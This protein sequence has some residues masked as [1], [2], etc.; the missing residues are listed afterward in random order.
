MLETIRQFAEEQLAATGTIDEVRDRHARYFAEQAVAHWD[1][2]DG[3]RQRV[4]VDW[5]DVEFAN[6]RA[7]FRWAADQADLVTAAAIAAHTAMLACALQ[8]FEPVGWAE[9]ILDAATAADLPQLPRLYTAASALLRTPGAPTPPSAT[10]RP[11]SRWRPIP[12]TTRS[13][14]DGA[15]SWEAVAHLLRRSDRPLPGDLRRPRPPSPGSLTSSGLCGLTL[16]AAGR[17]AGRGGQG[18]RRGDRGRRPRP[19][20][21]LLD[22]LRARR[23]RAGLRRGRSGP[24]PGRLARGPR[25][26][27]TSTDCRSGRRLIARDAAG[28]EAV[29]GDLE[30]ALAL[31][32]TAIDSFHRAGNVANLAAT[33][34]DLAVFFDRIER[35][36][37][38]A[39]IYGAAANYTVT[40]NA[41]GLSIAVD[42]LRSVL[43]ETAFD[44]CVAAGAAMEPADAVGYARDRSNSPAATREPRVTTATW[45]GRSA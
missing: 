11:R 42:H 32:D 20:Q 1:I 22:R 31:F 6:L 29:H 13:S 27:P 21:P 45:A 10:P 12:A 3:P 7:G 24:G 41:I 37:I 43:G 36:E 25:L 44:E 4:A 9:E 8:R 2:W 18:D 5:V 16:R 26:R 39:T 17:R 15:A 28:L 30:Q 23:V 19:R 40:P 33:L 14:P 38:A 35:P 34:A